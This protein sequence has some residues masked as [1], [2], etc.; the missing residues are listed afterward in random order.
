[1]G[2]LI[3]GEGRGQ[4]GEV[5]GLISIESQSQGLQQ[6]PLEGTCLVKPLGQCVWERKP[7]SQG[8]DDLRVFAEQGKL[9]RSEATD[10]YH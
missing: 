4:Q 7:Q 6:R 9:G 3:T 8:R 1:M 2:V 10:E 5:S